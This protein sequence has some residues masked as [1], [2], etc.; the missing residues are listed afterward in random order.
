MQT[1]SIKS[2]YCGE[3]KSTC[4]LLHIDGPLYQLE[5]AV[6]QSIPIIK[7]GTLKDCLVS[8]QLF[9]DRLISE[10]WTQDLPI[11]SEYRIN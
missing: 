6:A 8:G 7:R 10:G 2:L 3:M 11:I 9:V 5:T 1:V 4:E